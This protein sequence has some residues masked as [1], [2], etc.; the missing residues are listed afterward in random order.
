V[1]E[2]LKHDKIWGTICI[3]VPLLQILRGLVPLFSRDLR[4]CIYVRDS[5]GYESG[6]DMV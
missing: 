4:P 3:S 6:P 5:A 2:I 1:R